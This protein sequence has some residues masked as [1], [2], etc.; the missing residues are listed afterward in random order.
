LTR[1]K[2][3]ACGAQATGSLTRV[4]NRRDRPQKSLE[5]FQAIR[6]TRTI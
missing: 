5:L 4:P 6:W 2:L 3:S 1:R